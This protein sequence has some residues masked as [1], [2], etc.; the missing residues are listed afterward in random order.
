MPLEVI[1]TSIGAAEIVQIVELE[2]GDQ[3]AALLPD[4]T[5]ALLRTIAWMGPPHVSEAYALRAS[6]QCFII[7]INRRI[8]VVDTCIGNDKQLPGFPEWNGLQLDFLATLARIGIDRH[9]VTDVLC[10]HLHLDHVGWNT[11]KQDGQWW[12]TF[13][14]ARYH[15]GRTELGHW[16]EGDP[17]D[18]LQELQRTSFEESMRPVM[19]AGLM[20]LIDPETD[21]GDGIRVF[22]TPGHTPGHVAVEVDAGTGRFVIAGDVMHHPIQ[23]AKPE[24]SAVVDHDPRQSCATRLQLLARLSGSGTLFTCTHF[25]APSFGLLTQDAHDAYVFSCLPP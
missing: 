11:F 20:N 24:M 5:P 3:V 12:P 10:T 21:L 4:A 17:S 2:I 15:I 19:D 22:P 18:P 14:N 9:A 16:T 25:R 1:R 7:R 8:L 23:I 6:S 13:P